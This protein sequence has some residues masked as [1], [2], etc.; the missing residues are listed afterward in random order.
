M[1]MAQQERTV[2]SAMN[3]FRY[4][5]SY[6]EIFLTVWFEEFAGSLDFVAS[7]FDPERHGKELWI[8]AMAGE[9]G[10]I[11]VLPEEQSPVKKM[12]QRHLARQ[13]LLTH[14]RSPRLLTHDR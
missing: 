11:E 5:D 1:F 2:I 3:P 10:T 13:K 7:P 6:T 4:E 8:R 12:E 14:D 9:F